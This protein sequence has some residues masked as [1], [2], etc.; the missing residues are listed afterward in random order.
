MICS[1]YL[2]AVSAALVFLKSTI[3]IIDCIIDDR[4]AH[5]VVN[6]DNN[7]NDIAKD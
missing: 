1:R 2:A 4:L 7:T 3:C 6:E 5:K